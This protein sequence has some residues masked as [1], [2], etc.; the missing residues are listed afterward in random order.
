M[1]TQEV[2]NAACNEE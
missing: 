2:G 1:S